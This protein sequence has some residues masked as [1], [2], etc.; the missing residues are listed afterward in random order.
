MSDA[1]PGGPSRGLR[2]ALHA[3][4]AA[5]LGLVET[6]LSLVS[7]EL[8]EGMERVVARLVLVLVA[9]LCFAFALFATSALVVA[10][11]W[12]T[13]RIA[14]LCGVALVYAVIGLVALWRL[15]ALRKA[16]GPP[17][18]ETIAQFA[19]DRAWLSGKPGDDK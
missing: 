13:N 11:F 10:L 3:L 15:A 4:F 16:A 12:E 14:A 6:R 2:G 7:L 19:R 1:S 5:L 9:A 8:D 18:A 17:F